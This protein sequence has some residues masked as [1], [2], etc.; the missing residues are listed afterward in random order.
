M[1]NAGFVLKVHWD[2]PCRWTIKSLV[3]G[4]CLMIQKSTLLFTAGIKFLYLIAGKK[5]Y[6]HTIFDLNHFISLTDTNL[7][8]GKIIVQCRKKISTS[9]QSCQTQKNVLENINSLVNKNIS[10]LS[11]CNK[12]SWQ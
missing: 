10:A 11:D 1:R 6:L 4:R 12:N 5:K 8:P 9:F 7:F 3:N 2:P